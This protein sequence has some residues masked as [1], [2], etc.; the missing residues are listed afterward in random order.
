MNSHPI[1]CR[2]VC[3]VCL[4]AL[5]SR[6][7]AAPVASEIASNLVAHEAGFWRS[8]AQPS[9]SITSRDLFAYA[10]ILAEARQHPDRLDR[11]FEL[12]EQMQDRNTNSRS[13]GN[14]WWTLH[15]GKVM[16]DN[17]VDFAM[18]GGALLWLRQRGFI[19]VTARQR[20]EK[21]LEYSSQGCLR[22]QVQPSYSNIAIMNA[23]DLIL[24]GEA[25]EKPAVAAA[26]YARLDRFFRYT[27]TAGIHEFDSPTY[28]GVDLDGLGLIETFCRRETG[29]EQ[30]RAL[31]K[32]FWQ[33][34]ALNWF[35]PA[36]KL[37]GAQ[38][39]TYD[40]LHG[41]GDLDRHFVLNNWLPGPLPPNIDNL[42]PMLGN[43]GPP[44]TI[45]ELANQFP[46][47]V[48]QSWGTNRWQSRTH[49]L[50]PD[51]T[52]SSAVVAYGGRMDMPLTADL[53]GDRK[54]VR[55]YFIADGRDD[56]YGQKK[57]PAGAHQKTFHLD[58]FWAAA[59]RRA[60]AL[61]LAIYRAKDIP[62]NATTLVSNFVM[63]MNVDSFWIGNRRVVFS[64]NEPARLPVQPGEAVLFRKGG[65]VLG[66][67][68]PWSR[69]LDGLA[70][71]TFLIYDGNLFGAVRLAVEHVAAGTRPQ[72]SGHNAGAAFWVRIGNGL[73]T[74]ADF[75]RW[76]RQFA[77]AEAEVEARP[78]SL[79][80]KMAGTDGPI[81]V[82]ANAP[83]SAPEFIDPAP[84]RSVLALDGNDIAGTALR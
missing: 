64:T 1:I 44:Q 3:L 66:L 30:A 43:W 20:L 69:G 84:T 57:I 59:Q 74:D 45:S 37:A 51:I 70:A 25:L 12:A 53:P 9:E 21:L 10:L 28:T 40:Y 8:C 2:I 62:T 17:A 67:R 15:D 68:V 24:L 27:Q 5:P 75:S 18:R 83:W 50:L 32:L 60:D 81:S 48:Q 72:Y 82:A 16:D 39:R 33:D 42:F 65:A 29:R 4:V 77:E 23:G 7:P 76:S 61:G 46:R 19:P 47:L 13:Y 55:C 71:Q 58:P 34:I 22:H 73:K 38:S 54:S 63:P 49:F 6:L 36:Q 26:G 52:L 80:L 11:L 78:E 56:P 14:F 79:R 35:P 31:L 41:L